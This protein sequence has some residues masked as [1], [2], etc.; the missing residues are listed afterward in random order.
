MLSKLGRIL[1]KFE[2]LLDF[3]AVLA[4][5]VHFASLRVLEFYQIIL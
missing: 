5:P 1:L 3:L 2:F 4:G